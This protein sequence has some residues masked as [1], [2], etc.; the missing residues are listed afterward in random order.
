LPIKPELPETK[1]R[2][3]FLQQ[4]HLGPHLQPQPQ[5]RQS[6]PMQKRPAKPT[7]AKTIRAIAES[8][9]PKMSETRSYWKNPTRPQFKAPITT[10]NIAMNR[11]HFI[12]RSSILN[13]Y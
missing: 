2:I 4:L 13:L 3:Y 6:N 10:S 7:I 9:P 1:T 11:M 5:Q 12:V 8:I